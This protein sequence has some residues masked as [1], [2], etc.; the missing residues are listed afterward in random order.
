MRLVTFA[1][2][3]RRALTGFRQNDPLRMAAATAFFA[4]F[5][6][7]A[8]LIILI[9]IFGWFVNPDKL[10]T[11]LFAHLAPMF[12]KDS[13]SQIRGTLQG[14]RK[15]AQNPYI[16]IGGFLFL[17]FVA[18]T[19]FKIIKDSLNQLWNI[20]PKATSKLG[21]RIMRRGKSMIVILLAGLLFVA[22]MAAETAQA[23]L[24][25]YFNE[26]WKG[27]GSFLI[28]ALNQIVSVGVVTLW[29][30]VLFKFLPDGH[31]SWKVA[32]MG[33]LFTGILFTLGKLFLA[34]ML[35]KG[36]LKN[37]YGASGSFVL[38]LL[39]VFY[40]SMIL[41]YGGMFTRVWAEHKKDP[42][43]PSKF[44]YQYELA[45]IKE[46]ADKQSSVVTIKS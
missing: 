17:T 20:R 33:G 5:A 45:E 22:V 41:Y 36:N 10:S 30:T 19:L 26:Y 35:A 16:T 3:L 6:L 21:I 4:T 34:W 25:D 23:V 24:R 46:S 38:V 37:I 42:I 32:W 1:Q 31:P 8:I 13:V 7:P 18:T 14:F 11:H 12:G 9:Q 44:A 2:L 39:F 40:V 28:I 43:I 15:L 27:S 29:F